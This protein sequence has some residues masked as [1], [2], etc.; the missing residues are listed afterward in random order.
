M[1]KRAWENTEKKI[2][3]FKLDTLCHD[4]NII[5][6][7]IEGFEHKV[8]YGSIEKLINLETI[9]LEIHSWEDI[10]IHGWTLNEHNIKNDSLNKMLNYFINI[11]FTK[12]IAVKRN[13]NINSNTNWNDIELSS[14][15]KSGKR[16]YYKVLN[17]IIK[18]QQT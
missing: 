10:N 2:N 5:K 15:M 14:Y 12:F 16:V 11:G 17:V 1:Q 18:K 8:V 4:A 13:I 3:C 9:L 7:D 6:M